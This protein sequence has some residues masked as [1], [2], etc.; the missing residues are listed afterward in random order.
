MTLPIILYYYG[1]VSLISVAANLL[2][3]PTL[4]IVMGLVFMT[5]VV[6]GVP[7]VEA[8]VSFAA[9]KMIDYH[10]AVVDF[11]GGMKSF[12]VEIEPYQWWVFLLYILIVVPL[13]I[14][15]LR[16]KKI[17]QNAEAFCEM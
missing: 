15:L 3:L 5:G 17:R 1:M 8:V 4:P 10:M 6:A 11:F 12:M 2:I 9:T 7:A 14:G 13:I 16:R